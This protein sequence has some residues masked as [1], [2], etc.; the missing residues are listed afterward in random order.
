MYKFCVFIHFT[1]V[2]TSNNHKG[3]ISLNIRGLYAL[4]VV[5]KNGLLYDKYKKLMLTYEFLYSHVMIHTVSQIT[6]VCNL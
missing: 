1:F 5:L 2:H 3:D 6:L 4:F